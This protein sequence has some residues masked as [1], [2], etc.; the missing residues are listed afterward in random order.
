MYGTAH[1]ASTQSAALLNQIE[2][3]LIPDRS[4]QILRNN[5][6]DRFYTQGAPTD[7][8][9]LLSIQKIDERINSFDITIT[10]EATRR[11]VVLTTSYTLTDRQTGRVLMEPQTAQAITS[12]NVL[13][14]EYATLVTEQSA[15]E[16]G[17]GDIA[18]QIERDITLYLK[19][20]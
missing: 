9:F 2:I 13:N 15:R 16:A 10:A 3:G 11:Q 4:G 7:A 20:L 14:S 12:Y 19:R 8:P 18:R 6:I 1:D 17:L 5:L